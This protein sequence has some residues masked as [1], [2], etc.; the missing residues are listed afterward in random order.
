MEFLSICTVKDIFFT[1]PP[2]LCV[3]LMEASV[4]AV[5]Q[6]KK[7]GVILEIYAIP[8]WNRYAVICE[9]DSGEDIV[10]TLSAMPMGGLMN[11][12]VYPLSDYN[13]AMKA[14]IEATKAAEKMM[15]SPP[16]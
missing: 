10:R 1:L 15:P 2:A 4:A 11:Y 7:E 8:G 12:E 3:Q 9:H 5:N 14:H 6:K 13:E 16:R